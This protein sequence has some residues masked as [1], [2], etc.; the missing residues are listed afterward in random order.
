VLINNLGVSPDEFGYY[1][2]G[3]VVAFFFGS[4][5][6]SQL[7]DHWEAMSLLRHLPKRTM[8]GI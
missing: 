3:I 1:Q 2:A 6:A 5:L 8:S 7:A 4:V